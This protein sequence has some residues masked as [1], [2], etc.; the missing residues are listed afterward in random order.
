M[1]NCDWSIQWNL[2]DSNT[3]PYNESKYALEEGTLFLSAPNIRILHIIIL[4][5]L[6]SVPD[7]TRPVNQLVS[8][9]Y[10]S[11]YLFPSFI[12][13]GRRVLLIILI[14]GIGLNMFH[15]L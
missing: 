5:P 15:I 11:N 3:I 1:A 2:N 9:L 10:C 14:F 4:L 13:L 8:N 7:L 6:T 12:P